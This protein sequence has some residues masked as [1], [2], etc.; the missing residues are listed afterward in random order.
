[1]EVTV[2]RRVIAVMHFR[3]GRIT[4]SHFPIL[5]KG[6]PRDLGR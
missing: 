5:G 6:G 4:F 3:V 2:K 1:M